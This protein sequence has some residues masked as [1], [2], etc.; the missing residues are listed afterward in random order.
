MPASPPARGQRSTASRCG[1][2]RWQKGRP[3]D[4]T[5]QIIKDNAGINGR[6]GS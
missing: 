2:Y 6:Q 5:K 3:V 4:G 1:G